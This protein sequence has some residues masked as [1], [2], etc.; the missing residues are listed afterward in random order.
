MQHKWGVVLF[1][2]VRSTG[3]VPVYITYVHT[4]C[5]QCTNTLPVPCFL[6]YR[7]CHFYII[8]ETI[9]S[10]GANH[11]NK[12]AKIKLALGLIRRQ[13]HLIG[14]SFQSILWQ[15]KEVQYLKNLGEVDLPITA[16]EL[17][18]KLE[19]L[20]METNPIMET[21]STVIVCLSLI[22]NNA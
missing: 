9:T 21:N 14:D 19:L 17:I 8:V 18:H 2:V 3:S 11:Q 7:F 4:G 20:E 16:P 1:H 12:V 15:L 10:T 6:F 5:V 22:I 13:L